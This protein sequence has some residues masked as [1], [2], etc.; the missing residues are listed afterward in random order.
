MSLIYRHR[1]VLKD[2]DP[3]RMLLY[4]N[5]RGAPPGQA[6]W[7]PPGECNVETLYML[8]GMLRRSPYGDRCELN[9]FWFD[10]LELRFR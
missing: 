2:P 10:K 4:G 6:F 3:H 7:W 9:T 5:G 8:P 1:W